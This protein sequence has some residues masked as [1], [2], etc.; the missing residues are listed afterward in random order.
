MADFVGIEIDRPVSPEE[1]KQ[2]LLDAGI[3]SL[4][5]LASSLSEESQEI[6]QDDVAASWVIKVWRLER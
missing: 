6:A 4:D 2:K 1:V 5:A 3:D